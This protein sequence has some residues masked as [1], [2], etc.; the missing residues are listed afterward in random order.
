MSCE[1]VE[2]KERMTLEFQGISYRIPKKHFDK[3]AT[4]SFLP[5]EI[6][7]YIQ[8]EEELQVK[9]KDS[10]GVH[11]T[12]RQT[13]IVH[14]PDENSVWCWTSLHLLLGRENKVLIANMRS[15]S[16]TRLASDI[17]FLCR[18]GNSYQVELIIVNVGSFHVN[19]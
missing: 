7:E 2:V 19:L 13:V 8:L 18:L 9:V 1:I 6:S 10:E 11:D 14:A 4:V 16:S 15:S 5:D 3:L 17:A 12:T